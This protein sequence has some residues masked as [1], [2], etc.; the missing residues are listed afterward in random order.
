[1]ALSPAT[2]RA[3]EYP[4]TD[5]RLV[6][7]FPPKGVTDLTARVVAAH[8]ARRWGRAV[9]VVNMTGDGSN[10]GV[11]Q[12]LTSAPDGAT[13]MMTATGAG[14]QNPAVAPNT[15][16]RW[17]EPAIMARGTWRSATS[18]PTPNSGASWTR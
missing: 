14:T 1:M 18:P 13:M 15:P 11:V 6:V 3:G 7:P 12:V 5:V 2:T 10:T 8:L 9:E 17:D 16:Y 4:S